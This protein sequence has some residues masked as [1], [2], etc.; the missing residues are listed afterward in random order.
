M[1]LL[2]DYVLIELKDKADMTASGIFLPD[3]HNVSYREGKV[4]AVGPGI[5]HGGHF[6]PLKVAPDNN[7]TFHAHVGVKYKDLLLMRETD[8]ITIEDAA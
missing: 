5:Y 2:H 7:V 1:Q 8:I 6:V 3:I 4:K